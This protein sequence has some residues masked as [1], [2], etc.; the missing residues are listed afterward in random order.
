MSGKM[1]LGHMSLFV[2]LKLTD[3]QAQSLWA[4]REK[5]NKK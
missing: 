1:P 4:M 3:K 5:H 2:I